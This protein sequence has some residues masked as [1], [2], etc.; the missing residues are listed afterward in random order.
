MVSIVL[1][2]FISLFAVPSWATIRYVDPTAGACT[3]NYS[4]AS[5]NCTGSDGNSY[6]TRSAV[7]TPSA[8]DTTYWRT[9]VYSTTIGTGGGRHIIPL[10]I[11]TAGAYAIEECYPGDTC[12]VRPPDTTYPLQ[13]GASRKYT[14]VKGFYINGVNTVGEF[15]IFHNQGESFITLE[16]NE[17]ANYHDSGILVTGSGWII[18]NN[19]I[20][21]L[22]SATCAGGTGFYGIYYNNGN[23]GLIEGNIIENTPGGGIQSYPNA[24]QRVIIRR[25][26]VKNT[27]KTCPNSDAFGVVLSNTTNAEVYNNVIYDMGETGVGTGTAVGIRIK[28]N[29]V[30]AKIY[31]NTIYDIKNYGIYIDNATATGTRLQNN[32]VVGN[33]TNLLNVGTGTIQTTNRTTGSITDCTVS[34]SNFTHKA[35]S[36]CIDAGTAL[37]GFSY[38]GSAPDQGAF[39]TFIFSSCEVPSTD[40]ST[41]RVSFTNN[42][43][44]P[45]LP[46][47][48]VTGVTGRKNGSNNIITASAR[49]GTNQ[50]DFTMTNSYV[51]GDTVDISASSTNITDSAAI[52]STLSTALYQPYVGTLSNQSCTNNAAGVPHTY[53]Q[54][55]Y[56]FHSVDGTE[57]APRMKPDG[58]ASTGAA[59][60]F[61]PLPVRKGG[62]IRLRYALVCGG[63]DCPDTSFHLYY[64]TG[65]AYAILPDTFGAG[66][67]ATCG[68]VGSSPN[69]GTAT[70]NQLS[71]AG[72]FTPGG[73]VNT[74][75]AVPEIA[76]FLNGYKT[77]MEFCIKFDTDASGTYTFRTYL[78]SG[79]ALNTYTVT[80]TVTIT[81]SKMG[82]GF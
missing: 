71:T 69:S 31:K 6:A 8:G 3:G 79:V 17:I 70:T 59:E 12:E 67:V 34:T 81:E 29:V 18:R 51:G 42:L 65:G 41:I 33:G 44:P 49:L 55:R 25:N 2:I 56:E 1:T 75:N 62:S 38:N 52:G 30:N 78:Q 50:F 20:H 48:S 23:D 22:T 11:G 76:G 80:P 74:S 53:T 39:E 5:R 15:G 32:H 73:Y 4:I 63:A 26:V 58:F 40:T 13:R 9:A 45:I 10:P 21:D 28:G 14:K 27:G 77:E 68:E 54:A 46:S 57:A 16:N 66:N 72:T 47:S 19:Y 7:P 60:N 61:T 64:S 36:S 37:S 82:M 35:A 43:F 24:T